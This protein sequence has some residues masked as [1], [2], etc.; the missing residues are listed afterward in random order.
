VIVNNL[1]NII[2]TDNHI[3]PQL[4][5]LHMTLEFHILDWDSHENEM[6]LLDRT[7]LGSMNDQS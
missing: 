4:I 7:V 5:A 6:G 3:S 1:T 2:K